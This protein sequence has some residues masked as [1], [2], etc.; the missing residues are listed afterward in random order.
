MPKI[1][2]FYFKKCYLKYCCM[3]L[4]GVFCFSM[5]ANYFKVLPTST[6][7]N[8]KA[9]VILDAGH[10]GVDSG[11]HKQ[12]K[13]KDITLDVVLRIEKILEDKGLQV[14]LTRDKDVDL[15][16]KL[17]KGRHRRDLEAR[18]NIINKGQVAVSIHVNAAN[19]GSKEGAL[20]L[21]SK[22]S[23][24]SQEMAEFILAEIAKVQKLCEPKA[25][26]RKN[27][28]LLR[29]SKIPMVLVELGFLTNNRDW[30]KLNNP[31]FRQS[32]AQAVAN[33]IIKYLES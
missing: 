29:A 19:D 5:I 27:L 20:V 15:G 10:G 1:K 23:A 13:E 2:V 12:I 9:P 33:G 11:A 16:G 8:E 17:T 24:R 7:H 4:F 31:N 14:E 3:L 26:P 22:S 21:Y 28:F 25:I 6:L 18:L 30:Q 32:C